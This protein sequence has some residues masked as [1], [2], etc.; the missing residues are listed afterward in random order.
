MK[1]GFGD[2]QRARAWSGQFGEFVLKADIH[3]VTAALNVTNG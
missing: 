1:Q 3:N 2:T